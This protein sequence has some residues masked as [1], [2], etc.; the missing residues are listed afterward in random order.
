MRDQPRLPTLPDPI[1]DN[2][3]PGV[4]VFTSD[5]IGLSIRG[6]Q[7]GATINKIDSPIVAGLHNYSV[8]LR[9]NLPVYDFGLAKTDQIAAPNGSQIIGSGGTRWR[10]L[11]INEFH[12][13]KGHINFDFRWTDPVGSS[14][15]YSGLLPFPNAMGRGGRESR[16]NMIFFDLSLQPAP[17]IRAT[18]Q[19][20]EIR[21]LSDAGP[22][23]LDLDVTR[24]FIQAAEFRK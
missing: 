24:S 10:S 1:P 8:Q 14:P 22:N 12:G 15:E 3:T 11:V 19:A 17:E 6:D 21:V 7:I 5:P 20:Y 4:V 9:Q 13:K 18:F 16:E 23:V 2:P